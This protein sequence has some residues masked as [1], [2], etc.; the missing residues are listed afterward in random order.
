MTQRRRSALTAR[1]GMHGPEGYG[2]REDQ[3]RGCECDDHSEEP[4]VAEGPCRLLKR[5]E[6][7]YAWWTFSNVPREVEHQASRGPGQHGSMPAT[8]DR[9]GGEDGHRGQGMGGRALVLVPQQPEIEGYV[10]QVDSDGCDESRDIETARHVD[11]ACQDEQ[12]QR[13]HG[14]MGWLVEKTG[15]QYVERNPTV[16]RVECQRRPGELHR[17]GPPADR[18]PSPKPHPAMLP[19]HVQMRQRRRAAVTR[20][21][22][23]VDS[24]R[25]QETDREGHR[26]P[27]PAAAA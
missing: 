11:E 21:H 24:S 26:G 22:E 27:R 25:H 23:Q 6:H 15:D 5:P 14:Q 13:G 1:K 9:R 20:Q 18:I 17:I 10:I 8:D 19:V 16:G 12:A 4:P 2:S 7:P 3:P